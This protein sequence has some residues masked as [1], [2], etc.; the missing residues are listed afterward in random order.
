MYHSRE[1]TKYFGPSDII[2][3]R[4]SALVLVIKHYKCIHEHTYVY[5]TYCAFNCGYMCAGQLTGYCVT[6][7]LPYGFVL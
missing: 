2:G 7:V 4:V 6:L 5:G 3:F 1:S